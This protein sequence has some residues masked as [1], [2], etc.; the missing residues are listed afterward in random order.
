MQQG[1]LVLSNILDHMA[2]QRNADVKPQTI[3]LSVPNVQPTGSLL[4]RSCCTVLGGRDK[5]IL[6]T[7][8]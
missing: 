7:G 3:V 6:K 1:V 8:P 2:I 4:N 5:M